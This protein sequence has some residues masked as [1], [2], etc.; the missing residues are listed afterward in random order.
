[1]ELMAFLLANATVTPYL[2]PRTVFLRDVIEDDQETVGPP[3]NSLPAELP[4]RVYLQMH[5][6]LSRYLHRRKRLRANDLHAIK[7]IDWEWDFLTQTRMPTRVDIPPDC[8]AF[9]WWRE[10]FEMMDP[11]WRLRQP[12]DRRCP[13]M[14]QPALATMKEII[15]KPGTMAWY[16]LAAFRVFQAI[17]HRWC[18]TLASAQRVEPKIQREVTLITRLWPEF[19]PY[20]AQDRRAM[21]LPVEIVFPDDSF[22]PAGDRAPNVLIYSYAV[23]QSLPL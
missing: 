16:F 17:A 22:Q 20:V 14:R 13:S 2:A 18:E 10:Y 19:A 21:A 1:M 3:L 12:S 9:H 4:A 23:D 8:L 15:G 11:R 5:R 7:P 6:G